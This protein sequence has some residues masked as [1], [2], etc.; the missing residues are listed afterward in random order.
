MCPFAH[1]YYNAQLCDNGDRRMAAGVSVALLVLVTTATAASVLRAPNEGARFGD[2]GGGGGGSAVVAAS[3][4]RYRHFAPSHNTSRGMFRVALAVAAHNASSGLEQL[5]PFCW[6]RHAS[7]VG[8]RFL[9]QRGGA[10]SRKRSSEVA[11]FELPG[12]QLLTVHR[13]A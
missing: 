5:E 11:P 3:S 6:A 13:G 10:G 1:L 4:H 8:P 7:P 2:G 12:S 9:G